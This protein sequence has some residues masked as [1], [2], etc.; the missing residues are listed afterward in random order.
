[1]RAAI[2]ARSS[3]SW[4]T[5]VTP[6]S[7]SASGQARISASATAS[8]TSLPMSVSKTIFLRVMSAD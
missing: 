3:V 6:T 4:D 1:M 5:V 2:R 7:S 8:S